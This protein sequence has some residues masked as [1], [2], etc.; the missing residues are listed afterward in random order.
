MNSI[1]LDHTTINTVDLAASVL[2]YGRYLG[3]RPGWRPPVDVGGAWLYPEGSDYAI[4]H[5]IARSEST[6]KGGMLDH[7]A[8]RGASLK[9]YLAKLK[10]GGE[11]Y[12]ASPVPGTNLVQVHHYDPNQ[13][14]IEVNFADQSLD[15]AEAAT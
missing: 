15:S 12:K 4:V 2:F 11:S 7:V 1:R 3:L 14:L 13:V 6:P 5:L 10:S 8:F 9:D